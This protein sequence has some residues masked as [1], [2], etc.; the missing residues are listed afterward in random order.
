[1]K[2]HRELELGQV[3]WRVWLCGL[4]GCSI[5]VTPWLILSSSLTLTWWVGV[6]D[7]AVP[8]A[9]LAAGFSYGYWAT[10]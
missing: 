5:A 7:I 2:S 9:G 3:L 10:R 8:I 1:V 6:L 4:I